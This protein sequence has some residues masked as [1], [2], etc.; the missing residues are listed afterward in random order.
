MPL[1][2]EAGLGPGD[3]VLDG[4]MG[5]QLSPEKGHSHPQ[6]STHVCWGIVGRH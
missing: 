6:F 2:M 4:V 3:I 5:T 1:G